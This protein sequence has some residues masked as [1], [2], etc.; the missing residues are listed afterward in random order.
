[1]WAASHRGG[2]RAGAMPALSLSWASNLRR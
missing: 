2:P 1:V